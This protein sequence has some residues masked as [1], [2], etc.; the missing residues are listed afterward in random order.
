MSEENL[1]NGQAHEDTAYERQDLSASA[2]LAFLVGLTMTVVVIY[3]ILLWVY[4]FLD[5]Y[6]KA[7]QPPQNPLVVVGKAD[8]RQVAPDEAQRFPQPRLENTERGELTGF[9]LKEER[10]L[11]SYGWIDEKP[12]VVRIPIDRAMQ[13]LAQRGLPVIPQDGGKS[14]QPTSGKA[15]AKPTGN[16]GERAN[17]AH[18]S[19]SK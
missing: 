12:G 15:G 4:G 1:R 8:T 16:S 18:A 11:N 5:N 19:D 14:P 13:L 3:F 17:A 9:R 6:Q 2:V 7:H 10:E